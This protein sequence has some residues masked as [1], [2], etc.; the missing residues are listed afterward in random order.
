M[1]WP[2]LPVRMHWILVI[3]MFAASASMVQAQT[4]ASCDTSYAQAEEAYYAADFERAVTLLRPCARATSLP[5]STRA[6]MYRLLSFVYLGQNEQAAAQRAVE[7][8]LD[9]QPAYTPNPEEDRPDFIALTKKV[10]KARRAR[11]EAEE[12]NRRWLRWTLGVAAAAL[13]TAAVLLFGGGDSGDGPDPLP[14]PP[15]P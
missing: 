3:A 7:S 5:D 12:E 6:Q 15:S 14:R 10:R 2:A 8:L 9:L 1:M 4:P 13:G 11:A